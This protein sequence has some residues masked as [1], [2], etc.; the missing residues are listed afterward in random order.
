MGR[1]KALM[2]AG[3]SSRTCARPSTAW[4]TS[5]YRRSPTKTPSTIRSRISWGKVHDAPGTAGLAF[6]VRRSASTVPVQNAQ[7]PTPN[8]QPH[9]GAMNE[10]R[11]TRLPPHLGD[12]QREIEG[13]AR[14][15]GLEF[16]ETIFEV[17]GYDEINMVAANGGFSNRYRHLRFGMEYEQLAKGYEYGLSK[18]YGMGI[19]HKS[20]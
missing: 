4:R 9:G 19:H 1:W 12:I 14:G 11:D 2:A 5:P 18:I 7:R 8:A 16:Y 13:Y 15:F 20:S 10:N 17:L 6:G 3:N